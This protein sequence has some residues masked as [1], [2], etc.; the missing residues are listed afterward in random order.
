[1][2]T[3]VYR[4]LYGQLRPNFQDLQHR[5]ASGDPTSSSTYTAKQLLRDY[6]AAP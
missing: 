5:V 2:A 6:V 1:M 3:A 4:V